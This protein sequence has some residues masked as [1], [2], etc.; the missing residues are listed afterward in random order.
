MKILIATGVYPP[1]LGGP[2]QYAYNLETEFKKLGHQVRVI[3]FG[4][5][6]YLPSGVRHLLFFLKALI[7]LRGVDFVLT[8]DT[9]SVTWPVALANKIWRKKFIIR[10]GGDFLWESYLERSGDL[11]PFRDF[12]DQSRDRWS[13][14]EQLIFRLTHWTLHQANIIAFSTAWQRDI[15]A[16]AYHLRDSMLTIVE[17]YFAPV[18]PHAATNHNFVSGGRDI[19]LKHWSKLKRVFVELAVPLEVLSLPY[20]QFIQRLQ[21]SYAAVLIS[22]SE[23][24]PNLALDALRYGKPVILTQETG[25]RERLGD[26]VLWVDPQN[27]EQIKE[28]VRWLL[29][30]ENYRAMCERVKNL[31]FTHSWSEIANEFVKLAQVL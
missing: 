10:T 29:V 8:L 18:E 2:A 4:L 9:F 6:N 21:E 24:S 14:K 7:T 3:A 25:L 16:K 26:A 22:V 1:A 11:V 17:N 15:F 31:S 23:L 12:Y 5:E 20:G 28:Q 27:E 13:K 30:P 19:K